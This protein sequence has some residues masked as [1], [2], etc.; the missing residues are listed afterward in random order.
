M[1]DARREALEE[2][3]VGA[4]AGEFDV[5]ETLAAHASE[6]NFHAALVADHA[7]VLHPLVLAAETFPVRHGSEDPR[8]EQAVSLGLERTV[9]D[10]FRFGDF[11]V[12]PASDL[13][14]RSQRDPDRVKIRD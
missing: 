3:N 14:R 7:P 8:A 6:R 11:A 12:T 4:G 10:C 2:P 13:L 9:I 5:A 1:A